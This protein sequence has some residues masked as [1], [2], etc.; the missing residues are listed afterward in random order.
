MLDGQP[1]PRVVLPV[2]TDLPA[3][4]IT[5]IQMEQLK[6]MPYTWPFDVQGKYADSEAMGA[7]GSGFLAK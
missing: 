6:G 7:L 5:K 1:V 4:P 2:D 3:K